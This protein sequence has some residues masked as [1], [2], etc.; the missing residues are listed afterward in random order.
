MGLENTP[1][2]KDFQGYSFRSQLMV[3]DFVLTIRADNPKKDITGSKVCV[4]ADGG[5]LA[6][7]VGCGSWPG[8]SDREEAPA[9]AERTAPPG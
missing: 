4:S 6:I 7:W 2:Y 8:Q 1:D 9:P 5:I 3:S